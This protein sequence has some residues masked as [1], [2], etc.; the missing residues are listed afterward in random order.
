MPRRMS[1]WSIAILISPL[2][3]GSSPLRQIRGPLKMIVGIDERAVDAD[4]RRRAARR[5]IPQ[6]AHADWRRHGTSTPLVCHRSSRGVF[7]TRM[8]TVQPNP[9]ANAGVYCG[10]VG[11]LDGLAND[12]PKVHRKRF[13]TSCSRSPRSAVI[14]PA[15]AICR[16]AIQSFRA[17]SHVPPT[18]GG[19]VRGESSEAD[20]LHAST[21]GRLR[22]LAR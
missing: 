16:P 7:W 5:R 22:P 4:S 1:V 6:T 10:Q 17:G 21:L 20:Q 9:A 13:R 11:V 3:I 14:S 19:L 12:K 8:L 15:P 18:A 2:P